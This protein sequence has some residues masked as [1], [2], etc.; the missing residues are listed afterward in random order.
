MNIAVILGGESVEHDVSVLTGLSV[1]QNLSKKF[2]IIPIY[3]S[4]FGEWMTGKSLLKN[5]TYENDV[6]GEKCYFVGGNQ[7]LCVKHKFKTQKIR[8]DCAI[9]CLH[10]GLGEGGGVQAILEMNKVPYTSSGVG[11]SSLC[12]DKVLTKHLCR[13]LDIEVLPFVSGDKTD[14]KE[15]LAESDFD[16]PLIVKPARCGSSVGISVVESEK[17]LDEA[18][19]ISSQFDSKILIEPRLNNYRELNIAALVGKT[20]KISEIEEIGCV[21]LYDFDHKYKTSNTKHIVPAPVDSD[22]A[23][24]ICHKVIKFCR[25]CDIFGVVRFDFLLGDRLYLNEV[26]TIPGNIAFYL[27]KDMSYTKLLSTLIDNAIE[28]ENSRRELISQIKTNLLVNL[29]SIK[30]IR[31]K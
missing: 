13:A 7:E 10:G 1:M 19:N 4:R 22:I 25:E 14:I 11:A 5:S 28:R 26:N 2:T 30:P 8:I 16:Y 24:E 27:W 6:I 18:I 23:S 3:I 17:E 9:V 31:H 12:M 21:G 20:T 15:K 29:E